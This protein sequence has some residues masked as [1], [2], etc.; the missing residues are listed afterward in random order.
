MRPIGHVGTIQDYLTND[1]DPSMGSK[2]ILCA[3]STACHGSPRE[4]IKLPV[5]KLN[6]YY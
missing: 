1:V 3:T 5:Q 2:A 6:N 4:A